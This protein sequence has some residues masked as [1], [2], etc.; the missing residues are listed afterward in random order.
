M[1]FFCEECSES[2]DGDIWLC[3]TVRRKNLGNTHT[4]WHLWHSFWFNG[5]EI[6]KEA[7]GSIRRRKPKKQ[8][9]PEPQPEPPT[10]PTQRASEIEAARQHRQS[11][12]EEFSFVD[13]MYDAEEEHK[14][15]GS[16]GF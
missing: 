9:Q 5:T 4:C 8:Q 13:M 14:E 11:F 10:A 3:N 1:S 12:V 6:P 16:P 2:G 7:T 15:S